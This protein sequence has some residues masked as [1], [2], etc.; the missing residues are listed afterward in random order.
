LIGLFTG[1]KVPSCLS[2]FMSKGLS[3]FEFDLLSFC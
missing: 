2:F 3:K 1:E